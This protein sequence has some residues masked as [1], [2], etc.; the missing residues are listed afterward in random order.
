[1]RGQVIQKI[2]PKVFCERREVEQFTSFFKPNA[3]YASPDF[4]ETALCFG[5]GDLAPTP[6]QILVSP[7]YARICAVW[8]NR[9][10]RFGGWGN[11]PLKIKGG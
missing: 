11:D 1:M 4:V 6:L 5:R 3:A 2:T 9:V 7:R 8:A 10:S